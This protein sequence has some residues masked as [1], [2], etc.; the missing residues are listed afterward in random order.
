MA[1]KP[2]SRKNVTKRS[3]VKKASQIATTTAGR[4]PSHIVLFHRPSENHRDVVSK[5]LGLAKAKSVKGRPGIALTAPRKPGG[6]PARVY[7]RLGVAAVEMTADEVQTLQGDANV[8][9]VLRNEVRSIPTPVLQTTFQPGRLLPDDPLIAYLQ[10]MQDAVEIALRRTRGDMEGVSSICRQPTED[11]THSWCLELIGIPAD[12]SVATGQ[13]VKVAVLDT[14]IDLVHPDFSGRLTENDNAV[15]FVP[16]QSVLDGHGHGTHCV[17]CI[18]GPVQ[19]VGGK[20]YGVAPGV[21][22]LVG[23]V[24]GNNGFGRDDQIIDGID[25]AVEMGAKIISLS[26]SSRRAVDEPSSLLY[27][28]VAKNLL[29]DDPGVL[30]VAAAGNSSRRPNSTRPVENPAACPSLMAVAA[31]DQLKKIGAFSCSQ[32]DAHGEI[33][34]SGPG[35][36]VYSSWVDSGFRLNNGTSMATPHVAG[37]AALHLERDPDLTAGELWQVLESNAAPLGDPQD[38]GSGLVQAPF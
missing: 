11:T 31:V 36:A 13:G 10:G 22:L 14:G 26:L 4:P 18:A 1:T 35:V 34:I 3:A 38:F 9:M 32:M 24:L 17:G 5:T 12:Y 30:V 27:E 29:E 19:S 21:D 33:N 6:T 25:W 15:S 23:K 8:A 16:N 2:G 37:V 20:R 28:Q 7:D